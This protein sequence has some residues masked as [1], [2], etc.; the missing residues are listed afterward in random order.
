MLNG[1]GNLYIDKMKHGNSYKIQ[2]EVKDY[3]FAEMFSMAMAK[4]LDRKY[5][6][7]K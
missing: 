6:L 4:I 3:E 1:D 5:L 7:P 2:L